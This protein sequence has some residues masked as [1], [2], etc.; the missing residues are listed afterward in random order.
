MIKELEYLLS[1]ARNK[2]MQIPLE[3]SIKQDSGVDTD[4]SDTISVDD[5]VFID[6][7]DMTEE[8]AK[9]SASIATTTKLKIL[10]ESQT[11][12]ANSK[13]RLGLK[14]ELASNS[15][16]LSLIKESL[17]EDIAHAHLLTSSI[18]SSIVQDDDDDTMEKMAFLINSVR[19]QEDITRCIAESYEIINDPDTCTYVSDLVSLRRTGS[20]IDRSRSVTSIKKS[21]MFTGLR[22]KSAIVCG[23]DNERLYS[24]T[25]ISPDVQCKLCSPVT[26]HIM[27]SKVARVHSF[28]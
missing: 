16:T 21:K 22:S 23:L 25:P 20:S 11:T 1:S 24:V 9:N 7:G 2:L 3:T 8:I 14:S 17:K 26:H 5:D 28:V 19:E 18:K 10:S 15:S 4:N 27:K 12:G 6:N 13:R